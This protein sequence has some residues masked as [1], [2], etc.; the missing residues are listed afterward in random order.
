MDQPIDKE[1]TIR[2]VM[3]TMVDKSTIL[4]LQRIDRSISCK[5][6]SGARSVPSRTNS[7]LMNFW[8]PV[9]TNQRILNAF[10]RSLRDTLRVSG[11]S[12][13]SAG[14]YMDT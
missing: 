2:T 4:Y 9:R 1:D 8:K 12:L 14:T 3:S 10:G 5:F 13:Y 6:S 7:S 11:F